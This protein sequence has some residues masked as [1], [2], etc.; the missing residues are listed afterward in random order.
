M[1]ALTS[2]SSLLLRVCLVRLTIGMVLSRGAILVRDAPPRD[3]LR[4]VAELSSAVIDQPLWAL[5]GFLRPLRVGTVGTDV[6]FVAL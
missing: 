3:V 2:F 4:V 5:C 1:H 6:A